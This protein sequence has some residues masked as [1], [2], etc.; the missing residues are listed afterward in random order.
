M[1][2]G[3]Y[4]DENNKIWLAELEALDEKGLQAWQ[5]FECHQAH[6]T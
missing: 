2:E 6:L 4:R 3:F 5:N 1:Q